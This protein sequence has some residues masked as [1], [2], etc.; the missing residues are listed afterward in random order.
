[1]EQVRQYHKWLV[2]LSRRAKQALMVSVDTL[3]LPV[4]LLLA[5]ALRMGDPLPFIQH[6]WLLVAA[7]LLTIPFLIAVGFYRAMVRRLG[8]DS[9]F[10][11]VA[12]VTLGAISLAASAYMFRA[13]G[14]PR[15]V[16]IIYWALAILWLGGSRVLVRQYL[17]WM[18]YAGAERSRVAIYGAGSSGIQLATALGS[19]GHYVPAVFVDDDRSL[20]GTSIQ[21]IPV[22]PPA[23]LRR[24]VRRRR[25]DAVLLA[26]PSASRGERL[27]KVRFLEALAVPVKSVPGMQDILAGRASIADVRDVAIEEL[28]GRDPVPPRQELLRKCITGRSVMV[29]G[30]AGSIGSELCRQIL[31]LEPRRLVMVDHSEYGLYEMER[32]LDTLAAESS[33]ELV[34][35]LGSVLNG[36]FMERTCQ[37]HD[38]S[39]L[40]HAAAYKHVPMVEMNPSAGVRNNILGTWTMADAAGRAGVEYFILVSTDKA[41]RP[42]NVMGATKRFAELVLQA[43][44]ESAPRTVFSMVRFGNVMGSSGSVVPLFREQIRAGGPVTITH[45]EV[46]RYFMTIPEAAQLVIQAGSMSRGG[47]VF[48]L[49][50]GEPVRIRELA[51]TMIHLMGHT[52]REEGHPHGEIELCFTGLRPG[53]KLYEELLFDESG[54]PTEHPMIMQARE[55]HLPLARVEEVLAEFRK[56]LEEGDEQTMRALLLRYIGGY[57]P[58]FEQEI[59]ANAGETAP[60]ARNAL[61]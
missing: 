41:V 16:F 4:V 50:M 46:T 48:V 12:G 56:A 59:P 44:A 31:R 8:T 13:E 35:V 55:D 57:Q 36:G 32:E 38:I 33:V 14:T 52:V 24:L 22:L 45:P 18:L 42:T 7:P 1:M 58:R 43:L 39:T 3:V 29:T 40:Y 19:G 15:S 5:F 25:I 54:D 60:E 10:M 27:E 17:D 53:E 47:E 28:L 51:R 9:V 11:I 61:H 20:Q 26:M 2:G 6:P 23:R 49:D 37:Y 34:A 30:A 21:G